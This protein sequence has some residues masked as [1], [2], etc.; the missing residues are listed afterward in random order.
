MENKT[1]RNKTSM[2]KI[3]IS[4]T[5]VLM[6][7]LGTFLPVFA[8]DSN[9]SE[10]DENSPATAAITKILDMPVGTPIP[11]ATFTFEFEPYKVDTNL[12]D[13]EAPI[14]TKGYM[15]EIT[16]KEIEFEIDPSDPTK[17]KDT[18]YIDYSTSP[19]TGVVSAYKESDDFVN[20]GEGIEWPHAGV[21][22]Y[23]VTETKNTFEGTDGND[24]DYEETMLYSETKY[25]VRV[26]V[27]SKSGGGTYV[28]VVTVHQIIKNAQN[29]EIEGLKVDPT[30]GGDGENY[31]YSQMIFRNTYYRET[32]E[33]DPT[34]PDSAALVISKTV[35]GAYS[36]LETLYFDFW[37]KITNPAVGFN[38]D[39]KYKAYVMEKKVDDA[40]VTYVN[41]TS[42]KNG[43]I[44]VN[45]SDTYIEFT[46]GTT[47]TVKLLH[48]QYLVFQPLPVGSTFAVEE[49]AMLNY[50]PE[51]YL[52]SLN[53]NNKKI[54]GAQSL[55]LG[56]PSTAYSETNTDKY[57]GV[58]NN[59][60]DFINRY[61]NVTPT[62]I[63]VD[64]LPYIA[65]IGLVLISFATFIMII[66]RKNTKR[67]VNND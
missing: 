36:N 61:M 46:S 29:D 8:K 14:G 52:T 19:T 65:I 12:H 58:K 16:P 43:A 47:R 41:V 64:D 53:N 62:G 37:I 30:P 66:V 49:Q 35:L 55:P 27:E 45:G 57:I 63:S 40:N 13:P 51:Y 39:E 48:N 2:L 23:Y 31:D 22:E 17:Y 42:D 56:F 9:M 5:L 67:A 34:D 54:T 18:K 3:L 38:G 25:I 44:T 1:K 15:P 60:A 28:E 33:T 32:G 6:L 24:G 59:R 7:C 26:Y 10:G 21:Y 50:T 20:L 4:M 11:E